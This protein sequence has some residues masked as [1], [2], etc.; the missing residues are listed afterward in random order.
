[1]RSNRYLEQFAYATSHDLQEP[2]RTVTSYVQLL[3]KRYEGQLDSEA[4]DFIYYTI[5]ATGRMREMIQ[6]LLK[7]S[8]VSSQNFSADAV[9]LNEVLRQ[10][11]EDLKV[12]IDESRAVIRY[13][14]MPV[15]PGD[16]NMLAQLFQNLISNAIKYRNNNRSPLIEIDVMGIENGWKFSVRD[17][18]IGIPRKYQQRVFEVFSRVHSK[19]DTEGLGIGLALCKRIVFN[20]GGD[21]W[22]ES[23]EGEGSTF[24]FTIMR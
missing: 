2:L 5:D 16:R 1:M 21:I 24:Y 14:T 17:N 22:V 19:T 18:G 11:T 13:A 10:V 3:Q 23:Q 20:H 15:I 8:R 7:F 6:G 9:E 12:A 4:D